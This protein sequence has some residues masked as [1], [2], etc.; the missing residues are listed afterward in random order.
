MK[1]MFKKPSIKGILAE[2]ER[3][4]ARYSWEGTFADYLQ[5]LTDNSDISRLS[6]RLIYDSIADVGIEESPE[7]APVYKLFDGEIFG[8]EDQLERLVQYFASGAG[9]LEIRKRILLF[10]GPPASGK[11]TIVAL[12]KRAVERY[13]RTDAGA[14]YAIKGCPMQEEPLHLIPQATRPRLMEEFGVYVE[15]E[16]CS[17]CRYVLRSKYQGRV[18]EMPVTRFVFSEQEAVGIGYYVA[19]NPN[20]SDASLLV[21]SIDTSQLAGDRVE[22][23]GKAFR[24]DG[25]LN[26]AN[27]GLV[28]FGE[29]FKAD[30]HL[31][32]TLLG[33]AQEQLLKMER[34]G[35]VYVDEVVIA[36]S[37]LGDFETFEEDESSEALKDRLIAIQVP[38]NVR[39]RDETRIYEKML[40]GSISPKAHVAPLTLATVSTFAVLSRL[41]PPARQGMTLL[42]KLRLY[43]GRVLPHVSP[44]DVREIRRHHPNEGMEGMSPRYVMNRLST[45][46][47]DQS[48][49]C[50]SPLRALDAL[51]G[52]LKENVNLDP[53]GRTKYLAFIRDA[54]AEYGERA[55]RDVQRAY[56]EGFEASAKD[57]LEDYLRNVGS[58]CTGGDSTERDMRDIEKLAGVADRNRSGFRQEIHRYFANLKSRGVAYD[59]TSEQRLKAAI[60]ARLFPDRRTIDR[61]LS[62]PRFARNR[63]EWRRLRNT[64][65]NRLINTYGYCEACADDLISFAVH[66]V[67]NE[68]ILRTPKN[69]GIEWQWELDPVAPP[70]QED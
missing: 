56:K 30:R 10:I 64:V 4:A 37:N 3:D 21:G 69:E 2:S 13:T 57:L 41:E 49:V 45:V 60:E 16:L 17:R 44:D 55:V 66:F 7:G 51:W 65:C 20:P 5:L 38:Y 24:M 35:S 22:V 48:I 25:E 40:S 14:V 18:G 62:R 59:H 23:A 6:H 32:T 58:F 28:E 67:K 42:D 46:T 43:D 61:T 11:S 15:G 12:L 29:I 50:L 47:G 70:P 27:R 31:L 53:E 63:I 9:R 33:L 34:F 19:T 8:L 52:G 68:T 36:H 26:V 54:V 1:C 39:V